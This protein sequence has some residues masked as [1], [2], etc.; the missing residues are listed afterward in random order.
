MFEIHEN[1]EIT[2]SFIE[3]YILCKR[4]EIITKEVILC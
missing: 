1:V 4:R 2:P 3:Y